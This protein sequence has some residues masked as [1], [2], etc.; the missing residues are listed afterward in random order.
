MAISGEIDQSA[1][2]LV[3]FRSPDDYYAARASALENNVK[4]YRVVAG[5]REMIGSMEIDECA[6]R[7]EST[8][9]GTTPAS[10]APAPHGEERL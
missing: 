3:R 6:I 8:Q 7:F 1:G 10:A 4:L 9:T 2:I 5:R